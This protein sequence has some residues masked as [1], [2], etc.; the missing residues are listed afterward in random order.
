M[1][2]KRGTL[3]SDKGADGRV[4]VWVNAVPDADQN[5][6][7]TEPY[8]GAH[9]EL[10]EALRDE[11]G[12]LRRESERKDAIIL[13]LS[14]S[15]AELSRTIRQLEAPQ[16]P[17]EA[18]ETPVESPEGEEV[19]RDAEG[20][21]RAPERPHWREEAQ[22]TLREVQGMLREARGAWRRFLNR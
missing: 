10:M 13:S 22:D 16:E 15:N 7:H 19:W 17:P 11:I 8:A 14:Q 21:Q 1:R 9:R 6:V 20:P 18:P 12:H 5:T 3:R 2:V 4:Y